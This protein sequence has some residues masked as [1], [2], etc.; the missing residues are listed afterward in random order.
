MC[1]MLNIM[2]FNFIACRTKLINQSQQLGLS[3][4]YHKVD[5]GYPDSTSGKPL[6]FC[7][8]LIV[9]KHMLCFYC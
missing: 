1:V 4:Y 5:T 2:L 9:S 7:E 3:I 6:V 8:G